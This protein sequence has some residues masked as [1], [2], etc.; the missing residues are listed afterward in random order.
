MAYSSAACV[1]NFGLYANLLFPVLIYNLIPFFCRLYRLRSS[2]H[3]PSRVFARLQSTSGELE[4]LV[5]RG[6][7]EVGER[8]TVMTTLAGSIISSLDGR[9]Y[10]SHQRK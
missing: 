5:P 6:R 3:S 7:S 1:R 2:I 8:L 4:N 9:G 10:F